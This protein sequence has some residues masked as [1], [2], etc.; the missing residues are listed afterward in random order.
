MI[1]RALTL[2]VLLACGIAATPRPHPTPHLTPTPHPNPTMP[3]GF[4]YLSAVAPT[5]LQDIRYAGSHNFIGRPMDG[6]HAPECILTSQAADALAKVQ[7]D[8]EDAN[9]TLRV[10]DCYRPTRAVADVVAWS[11][12]ATDQTM[13]AAFYPNVDKSQLLALGYISETSEHSRGSAV[14]LTIERLPP[15]PAQ[16]F[17]PGDPLLPCVSPYAQRYHDGS[18]DM[19]TNFDCMDPLT[20]YHAYVGLIA[21]S[22]R[23]MLRGLMERYGFEGVTQA[24]WRF[25]LKN[26]PFPNTYF[27]FPIERR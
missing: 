21:D 17:A 16:P 24:W 26:E 12:V 10:Y 23:K 20:H 5:I 27:N 22:H 7:H 25:A 4:V 3:P 8:L 2:V 19:G 15:P 9:F 18:F 6:Y 13:K 11:R 14:D 1:R